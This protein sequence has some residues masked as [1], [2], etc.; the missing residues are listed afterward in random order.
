[1][2]ETTVMQAKRLG[3]YA[4]RPETPLLDAARLMAEEDISALVV[5][6]GQGA[7]AG[8]VS[9]IDLLRAHAAHADWNKYQVRDYM[10][11]NVV[12]VGPDTTLDQV[13]AT[14]LGHHIHRV[15]VVRP[16]ED[17]VRPVAVISAADL[18]Y[19]MV[20]QLDTTG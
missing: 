5:V 11:P 4:C 8:I 16:E 14:L 18:L 12:T 19:H 6:D 9:R 1:M 10:S 15:V 3:I 17:E 7:L 20:K 13:A 2:L